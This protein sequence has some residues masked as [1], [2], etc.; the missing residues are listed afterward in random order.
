[1]KWLFTLFVTTTLLC[2]SCGL[3][4]IQAPDGTL[5]IDAGPDGVV[6]TYDDL[7]IIDAGA[8]GELGTRDDV[9]VHGQSK[10][11]VYA[12]IGAPVASAFGFPQY[13]M[14]GQAGVGLATMAFAAFGPKRKED[15]ED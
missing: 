12:S 2:A 15:D 7:Y 5:A 13:A 14:M 9:A 8:D 1:M 11:Q 3:L 6:G 4:E 10:L